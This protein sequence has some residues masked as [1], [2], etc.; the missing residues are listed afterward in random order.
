MYWNNSGRTPDPALQAGFSG[1][2]TRA[3][4]SWSRSLCPEA[5]TAAVPGTAAAGAGG[6]ARRAAAWPRGHG[7]AH[8]GPLGHQ[9]PAQSPS[10]PPLPATHPSPVVAPASPTPARGAGPRAEAGEPCPAG[11]RAIGQ[12]QASSAPSPRWHGPH[13][14]CGRAKAHGPRLPGAGHDTPP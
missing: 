7:R 2:S 11:L 1:S 3:V 6:P 5:G 14:C 9:A 4:F 10:E 12:G 13:R 8:P